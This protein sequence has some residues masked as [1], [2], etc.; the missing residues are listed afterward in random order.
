MQVQVAIYNPF[1][2]CAVQTSTHLLLIHLATHLVM[3]LVSATHTHRELSSHCLCCS[4]MQLP[5]QLPLTSE[6]D[7]VA[8]AT[9]GTKKRNKKEKRENKKINNRFTLVPRLLSCSSSASQL[10]S[11]FLLEDKLKCLPPT[12]FASSLPLFLSFSTTRLRDI[13]V[14]H[15]SSFPLKSF[16]QVS[17]AV[18]P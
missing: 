8:H 17:S 12:P 1:S 9:H 13:S 15:A 14:Y 16:P 3:T 10:K 5:L 7:Y 18:R 2:Q 6:F 11:I 4:V